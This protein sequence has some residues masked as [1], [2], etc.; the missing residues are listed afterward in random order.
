MIL[1]ACHWLTIL[2][3]L[4]FVVGIGFIGFDQVHRGVHL[5]LA[6]ACAV[7]FLWFVRGMNG[8]Y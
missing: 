4:C 6:S 2:S 3:L 7:I 5:M 8:E 1:K